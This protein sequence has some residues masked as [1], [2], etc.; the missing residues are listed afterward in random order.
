MG[1]KRRSDAL[2]VKK[3][4]DAGIPY[5]VKELVFDQARDYPAA[6]KKL[7]GVAVLGEGALALINDND[8][9]IDGQAMTMILILKGIL[10]P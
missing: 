10:P 5:L 3:L 7:E 4:D 9:G 1:Q 6:P 8:F 2:Q